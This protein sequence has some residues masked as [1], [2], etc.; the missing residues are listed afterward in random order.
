MAAGRVRH[1]HELSSFLV[2]RLNTIGRTEAVLAALS[3]SAAPCED[4]LFTVQAEAVARTASPALRNASMQQG[5]GLL[6]AALAIWPAP[7]L[8]WPPELSERLMAGPM[9]PVAL[10]A[11]GKGVGLRAEELTL[12]AAQ[13]A[14]SGPAWA[15]T[16]LLGLDPFAIG[17]ALIELA[18]AVEEVAAWAAGLAR[19]VRNIRQVAAALPAHSAPLIE[20]GAENHAHREVRLFAS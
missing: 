20:I 4:A 14:V 17:R 10:G 7:Y 9:Y 2:G 5:R 12:V 11:V 1:G 13:G 19:D 3:W 6:R 16:R 18:P 8:A 15:A